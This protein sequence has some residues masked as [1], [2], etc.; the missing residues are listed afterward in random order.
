MDQWTD[1]Y[2]SVAGDQSTNVCTH[3]WIDPASDQSPDI[4]AD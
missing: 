2:P 3:G 4:A 1:Q